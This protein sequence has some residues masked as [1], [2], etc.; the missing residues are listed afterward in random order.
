[1]AKTTFKGLLRDTIEA[2]NASKVPIRAVEYDPATKKLRVEFLEA[3]AEPAP[4]TIP[5]S[6]AERLAEAQPKYLPGTH[7]PDDNSPIDAL[8]IAESRPRYNLDPEPRT[9]DG[10]SNGV[11]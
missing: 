7:I 4:V 9:P 6:L 3:H 11:A 1:V 2:V 10:S 5:G 8:E